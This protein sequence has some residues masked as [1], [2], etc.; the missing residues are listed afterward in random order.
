MAY[1]RDGELFA[2]FSWEEC[3][4]GENSIATLIGRKSLLYMKRFQEQ[5]FGGHPKATFAHSL[6]VGAL[7]ARA[8]TEFGDGAAYPENVALA[9]SVGTLHDW[10]K[11]ITEGVMAL[12]HS[13][14]AA[15]E[16]EFVKIRSHAPKGGAHLAQVLAEQPPAT[17]HQRSTLHHAS[18]VATHHHSVLPAQPTDEGLRLSMDLTALTKAADAADAMLIDPT[19]T[20]RAERFRKEGLMSATG[21]LNMERIRESALRGLP[22]AAFGVPLAGVVDLACDLMPVAA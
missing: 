18:Y 10:G 15:S 4:M 7:M 14:R 3:Q 12:I 22:E 8:V 2:G 5:E 6:R 21:A 16:E 1:G 17:A 11:Y 20:Y 13:G 9:R 19:R